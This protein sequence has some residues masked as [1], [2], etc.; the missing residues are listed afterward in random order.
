MANKT[1][2][3]LYAKQTLNS[4]L[5]GYIERDEKEKLIRAMNRNGVTSNFKIEYA[6]KRI[7]ILSV[8]VA[9]G[10][11]DIMNFLIKTGANINA[12]KGLAMAHAINFSNVQLLKTL[13]DSGGDANVGRGLL[14]KLAAEKN[15]LAA[16]E[17]LYNHGAKISRKLADILFKIA[18]KNGNFDIKSFLTDRVELAND[19]KADKTKKTADTPQAENLSELY[20]IVG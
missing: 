6:K 13:L 14:L 2:K 10:C 7:P 20:P 12:D 1:I 9:Y 16:M 3:Q 8:A 4:E 18:N 15:L 5:L 11:T 19:E 17:E